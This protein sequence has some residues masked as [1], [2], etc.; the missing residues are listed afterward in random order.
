M[1]NVGPSVASGNKVDAVAAAGQGFQQ[2]QQYPIQQS[3][4]MGMMGSGFGGELVNSGNVWNGQ[5]SMMNNGKSM[6]GNEWSNEV[7]IGGASPAVQN[8]AMMYHQ[9][10]YP[11]PSMNSPTFAQGSMYGQ[12]GGQPTNSPQFGQGTMYGQGVQTMNGMNGSLNYNSNQMMFP[13]T[14]FNQ[15]SKDTFTFIPPQY[16][17]GYQSQQL[18]YQ[19]QLQFQQQQQYQQQLQYEL[20]QQQMQQQLKLQTLWSQPQPYQQQQQLQQPM[21]T[22]QQQQQQQPQMQSMQQPQLQQQLQ[23][24]QQLQQYWQ[25]QTIQSQQ[26]VQSSSS[27]KCDRC[28]G[29]HPTVSCPYYQENRGTK[30]VTSL[31]ILD[32]NTPT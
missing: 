28:D 14:S 32:S 7:I 12:Q 18:Q 1:G 30:Y 29:N 10:A 21:F 24:L 9:P 25:A 15:Q 3:Q 26:P 4:Q 23:Q 31:Y 2:Q 17:Q 27:L 5:Q 6:G 13:T 20:Q 22:Q 16:Q 11:S 19:Q 8:N